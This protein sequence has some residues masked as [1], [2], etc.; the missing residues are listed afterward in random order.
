[1]KSKWNWWLLGIVAAAALGCGSQGDVSEISDLSALNTSS[2]G[3]DGGAGGVSALAGQ[4]KID[5]SSTVYPISEAAADDFKKEFPKVQVTVGQSGTGGGF[6]VFAKGETDI[7]DASRPI[8]Q[9]EFDQ[10][11]QNGVE[12]IELP[13]AYDG[14]TIVVNPANT[15]VT[16]LTVQQ[17]KKIFGQKGAAK[18]WSDVNPEWPAEAIKIYAPGT[19]S[20]TFDYFKEVVAEEDNSLRSDMSVSEDDNVLVTGVKG[21]K[22]A[23][24]FF[25]AAY[26]FENADSLKA[27]PIVNPDTGEAVLPSPQ[28]IESGAYAPFGRPLFIYVNVASLKRPE[29]KKF[30][31]FY[32]D[33]A[34]RFA[35][36]VSYVGLPSSVYDL[37]RTHLKDRLSGT[38]FIDDSGAKRSGALP[39]LYTIENL[40]K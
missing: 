29:M 30:A 16:Q 36:H 25:G 15:W 12:F 11:K 9:A 10:C 28:S 4:V 17:L 26:F 13:V 21:E 27:V 20:G 33:N 3:D 8:K 32:I 19:D 2:S 34:A 24:G 35:V 22:N 5:G 31:S 18:N 38:H 6:K 7:S 37:A 40:V 23:I 1:M 14:L 39:E